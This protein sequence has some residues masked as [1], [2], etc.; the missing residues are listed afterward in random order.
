MA[1]AYLSADETHKHGLQR[2]DLRHVE[3]SKALC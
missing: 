2:G 1:R 3:M